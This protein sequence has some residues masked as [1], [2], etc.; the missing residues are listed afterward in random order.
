MV[1]V[2][3]NQTLEYP[4]LPPPN[5][6]TIKY[7]LKVCDDGKLVQLLRSWTLSIVSSLSKMS[8]CLCFKTR[9]GDWILSSS[10]GKSYSVGSN[11]QSSSLSPKCCVLKYKQHD[12]LDKDETMDNVQE[13]NNCTTIKCFILIFK[14]L[15]ICIA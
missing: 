13:C 12:I 7:Y 2:Q 14:N 6:T 11:R 15:H 9:F 10:S 3:V 8:S 1:E 5:T 4:Y